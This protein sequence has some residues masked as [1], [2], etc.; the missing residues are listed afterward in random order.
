V[1]ANRVLLKYCDGGSFAGHLDEP[2]VVDGTPLMVRGKLV[3][4]ALFG[5][6][7]ADEGMA[8]ATEV[9]VTGES[10]GGLAAFLHA[11]HVKSIILPAAAKMERFGVLPISGFFL[12]HADIQGQ[13]T[14]PDQMRNVFSY[15]NCSGGVHPGCLA[16]KEAAE[17]DPSDCYFANETAPFVEVPLFV[18]NSNVDQWQLMDIWGDTNSDKCTTSNQFETCNDVQIAQVK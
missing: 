11:D 6:L 12:N 14:W 10:A 16:A 4:D 3:M 18:A 13:L 1:Q 9:L 15:M 5:A 2:L 8:G 17:G 7:L